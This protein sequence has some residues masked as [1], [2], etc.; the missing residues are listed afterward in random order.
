MILLDT[1]VVSEA[2]RQEP[3]AKVL[4]WLDR[5]S[6]GRLLISSITIAEICYGLRILPVG[7]RRHTLETKFEQF[8]AQG[9]AG[10]ILSFDETAAHAYAETMGVRKENGRP[11]SVPDA[12]IAAIAQIHRLALATRNCADFEDCGIKLIN[13]FD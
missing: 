11:M 10:R 2:M 7:S 13:P 4:N 5:H 1:N 6:D 12:Q 9:F 3:S 8:V